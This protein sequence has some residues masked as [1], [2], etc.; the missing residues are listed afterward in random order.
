MVTRLPGD[1]PPGKGPV[2]KLELRMGAMQIPSVT[3]VADV[4]C[5]VRSYWSLRP[6]AANR[7]RLG[8]TH[9]SNL[10]NSK[11][12]HVKVSVDLNERL[13]GWAYRTPRC[14]SYARDRRRI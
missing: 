9:G 8:E 6:V 13:L 4:V 1:L 14:I 3:S 2:I 7:I 12:I 11:A 10:T 5:Q